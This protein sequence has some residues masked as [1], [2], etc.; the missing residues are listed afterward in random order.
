[1]KRALALIAFVLTAIPALA[2]PLALIA[3][4]A[5]NGDNS[6]RIATT[7][8]VTDNAGGG[9]GGVPSGPAG[10]DLAGT[11][12]NPTI[13]TVNANVGSF[14]S[15]TSCV[16]FTTNAKGQITAASATTCTPAVASI[17][18]LGTGVA[19]ALAVNTGS[20]GAVV[21]NGGALGTPSSGVGTNLTALNA[22]NLASGTV[23]AA[24]GG[25][26]TINGVLA[27]NGSGVVSQGTC[28]GLSGVA[29]SCATDTTNA[30]N[31]SSG[32][33]AVARGGVDQTAWSTWSPSFSMSS[34]G[35]TLITAAL[36]GS[37][38]GA[39][40]KQ[41]GKTVFWSLDVTISDVGVGNGGAFVFTN[42]V[43]AVNGNAVYGGVG[44][45]AATTGKLLAIGNN[46]ISSM[47]IAYG[48]NSQILSGGNGTRFQVSGFYEAQ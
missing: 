9:G 11:Y 37:G 22:S 25:A 39:R 13:A 45:E 40:Y 36:S 43:N 35:G 12:P 31:I 14:G 47:T 42:P 6:N 15:A 2:D 29:A 3:P 30:N 33:L 46:S 1:M 44:R 23:A 34:P 27:G 7:K 8:W 19:A 17:T 24:R 16:A 48:D 41:I 5:P 10:G 28:A 21:V 26:G 32:T 20:A 38:N 4:N 18:G